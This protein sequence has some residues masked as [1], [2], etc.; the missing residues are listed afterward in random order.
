[1]EDQVDNKLAMLDVLVLVAQE[2]NLS[3]SIYCK[4]THIDHYLK[5][6]LHQPLEHK[7]GVIC[8]LRHRANI[9]VNNDKDKIQEDNHLTLS[10]AGYPKWLW[11]KPAASSKAVPTRAC[12]WSCDTAICARSYRKFS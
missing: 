11:D 1:M 3:F 12:Q 9:T 2:G 4:P 10:L 7:L 8:T 5:F 6:P